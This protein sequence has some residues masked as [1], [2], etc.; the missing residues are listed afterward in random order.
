[1][2]GWGERARWSCLPRLGRRS[3]WTLQRQF[4]GSRV[5]GRVDMASVTFPLVQ[6]A[7]SRASMLRLKRDV[8][9]SQST[10]TLAGDAVIGVN[11]LA[12]SPVGISTP[13]SRTCPM[14]G[15]FSIFT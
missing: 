3:D 1:M 4:V 8:E 5:D 14:V 13:H 10:V 9:G 12:P 6:K 2:D 11:A 7:S 15:Q